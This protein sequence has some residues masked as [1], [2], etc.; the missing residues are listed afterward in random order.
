ML[1]YETIM[2]LADLKY[3][4]FVCKT[5]NCGGAA[6]VINLDV[7]TTQDHPDQI[8]CPRCH[9]EIAGAQ[10]FIG[11][12]RAVR[13]TAMAEDSGIRFRTEARPMREPKGE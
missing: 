13:A 8:T 3:V 4:S 7:A 6:S 5:A 10:D 9:Q 12:F 11:K 1:R 2:D